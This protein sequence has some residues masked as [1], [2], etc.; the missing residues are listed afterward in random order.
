MESRYDPYAQW[1]AEFTRDWSPSC[2]PYLPQDLQ[3]QRVLDLACGVGTLSA[4]IAAR[5]AT[6]TAV[7]A[8][9]RMLDQAAAVAGVDYHLGDATTTDWWDGTP[10]DGV[11]S[12]MA[13]MDIQDLDAALATIATVTSPHGWVLISVLHPCFP[14]RDDT[15][16]LPSWSPDHGYSWE[17][18]WT[19]NTDGVRGRVGAHHRMLSTYLTAI[20]CAGLDMMEVIEP[21]SDVPRDLVLRCRKTRRSVPATRA[22]ESLPRKISLDGRLTVVAGPNPPTNDGFCS[23][24]VQVLHWR[25]DEPFGDVGTHL[26]RDSDEVYVVLEGG[27]DLI[28][29]GSPVH[30]STGEA[31]TVGAGVPHA[32]VAV[33]YP[34]RGL[35]IRG[36]AINDKVSSG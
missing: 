16:T 27:I 19:T 34:A 36:P 28:V 13:L 20:R 30:A 3:G 1:Y 26:H 6:V 25:V 11:V 23:D 32:L 17:G 24:R 33:H 7:D 21:P 10:F 12:N 9:A 5:G 31:V 14:G 22:P 4:L 29:D 8:S 18:W 35:T 15:G 2:L